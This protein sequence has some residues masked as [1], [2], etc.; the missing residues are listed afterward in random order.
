MYDALPC[1]RAV[2]KNQILSFFTGPPT[3]PLKSYS[4]ISGFG[5]ANPAAFSSG[6]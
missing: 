2:A 5:A 6:V 3:A 1:D 4:L